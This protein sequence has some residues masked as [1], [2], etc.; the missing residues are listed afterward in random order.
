MKRSHG[1]NVGR[2]RKLRSKGRLSMPRQLA[3]F[4]EGER[5]RIDINPSFGKGMPHLRFNHRAAEV[6]GKQGR[7]TKV[8]FLDGNKEKHL[9]VANV[10]LVKA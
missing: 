2:S 6:V 1:R 7:S 8:A 9:V 4:H 10:H 5:V 3:E